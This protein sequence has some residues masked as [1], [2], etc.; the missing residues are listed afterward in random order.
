VTT[1]GDESIYIYQWYFL[2]LLYPYCIYSILLDQVKRARPAAWVD[3]VTED[4]PA[5]AG[6]DK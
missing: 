2:L 6:Y 4:R 5:W 1:S 3:G